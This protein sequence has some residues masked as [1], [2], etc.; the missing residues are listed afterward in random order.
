[1]KFKSAVFSKVEFVDQD[2]A[3]DKDLRVL[4]AQI[5]QQN[6]EFYS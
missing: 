3:L 4:I 1:M 6:I 5:Q 2:R